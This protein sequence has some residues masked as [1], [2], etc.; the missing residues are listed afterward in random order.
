MRAGTFNP[1]TGNAYSWLKLGTIDDAH[2]VEWKWF[3]PDGKLYEFFA[4]QIPKPSGTPWDWTAFIH[5][6][7][8][9][10]TMRA[11]KPGNWHVGVFI[12]GQKALTEQ[13]TLLSQN[14]QQPSGLA[15]GS[16]QGGCHFDPSIGQ[17]ICVDNI[18]D[19]SNPDENVQGGCRTD[20]VTGEMTCVDTIGSPGQGWDQENSQGQSLGGCYQ[21]PRTGEIICIDMSGEPEDLTAPETGRFTD[22]STGEVTC[23]G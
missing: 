16:M 3:S 5:P 10:A 1:G 20:P 4:N 13:F 17:T 14:G 6:F 9:L 19:F 15:T 22:P 23:I 18:N 2:Q 8:L 12:D 7:P 11:Q 21:D